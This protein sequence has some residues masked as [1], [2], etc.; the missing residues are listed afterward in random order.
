MREI[1]RLLSFQPYWIGKT[2][3]IIQHTEFYFP[4]NWCNIAKIYLL[5]FTCSQ[6][7]RF[8]TL[9]FF[10]VYIFRNA[11]VG[12]NAWHWRKVEMIS[13]FCQY[14]I[15]CNTWSVITIR[16]WAAVIFCHFVCTVTTYC[17]ISIKLWASKNLQLIN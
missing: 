2:K 8:K 7:F 1:V 4:K 14:L 17:I 16:D 13:T 12:S 9:Y 15:L 5:F 3:L 10:F 11:K 6:I